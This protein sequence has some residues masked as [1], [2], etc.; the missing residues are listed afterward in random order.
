MMPER[1][2]ALPVESSFS[3]LRGI[4]RGIERGF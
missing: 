2:N 3:F 4:E 1:V